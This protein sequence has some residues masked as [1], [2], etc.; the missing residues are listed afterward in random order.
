MRSTIAL[1]EDRWTG[2]D[3]ERAGILGAAWKVVERSGFEGLKVQLVLREAGVS[4]RMFY[5]HF[6]D[7]DELWLALMRDE[8]ARAA[9]RLSAL[10]ARVDDPVEKVEMWIREIITAAGDP[11]RVARA[12][13]FSSQQ[14]MMRRFADD[15]DEGVALLRQPLVDA[16]AL[17]R[18]AGVFR[19]A[20]PDRDAALIYRLAGA[21]LTD[22][23][24]DRRTDQL[25]EVVAT[26]TEFA[27]RALGV[28]PA[29]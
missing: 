1:V 16:I 22:S 17:G 2:V 15:L 19:W 20:E 18:D 8:M 28:T 23:L 14:P 6:G 24:A 13:L 5:R 4:A 21:S 12:R 7:K 11:R 9:S 3:D 10:V 29:H 25:A 27:M 26:T